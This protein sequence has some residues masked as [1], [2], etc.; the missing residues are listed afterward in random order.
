MTVTIYTPF[1][2]MAVE[3][4]SFHAIILGAALP[5]TLAGGYQNGLMSLLLV[6][7]RRDYSFLPFGQ[8][9]FGFRVNIASLTIVLTELR[10]TP[11]V[12]LFHVRNLLERNRISWFLLLFEF[13]CAVVICYSTGC[14]QFLTFSW[15]VTGIC[16]TLT[17]LVVSRSFT[18]HSA[19]TLSNSFQI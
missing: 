18:F 12:L 2:E 14:A 16:S 5:L 1:L 17:V 15:L 8:L 13:Y 11:A 9:S 19:V 3:M 10:V 6:R 4:H 7:G